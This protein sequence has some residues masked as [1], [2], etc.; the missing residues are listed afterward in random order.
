MVRRGEIWWAGP[1]ASQTVGPG[2]RRPVLILQSNDFN[3]SG[4]RTT[5]ALA[6]TSNLELLNAPGNVALGRRGTG[7]SRPSVAN[8]SQ[9]VTLEK[10][11]LAGRAGKVPDSILAQIEEGVRLVLGFRR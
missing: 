1:P 9:I 2:H 5:L 6:V 10:R 11:L 7:L 3:R 4:I 8:V